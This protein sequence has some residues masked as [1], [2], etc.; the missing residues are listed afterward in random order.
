MDR[1]CRVLVLLLV[2]VPI[3]GPAVSY[4]DDLTDKQND[5]EK[6]ASRRQYWEQ[7]LKVAQAEVAT[8]RT[9]IAGNQARLAQTSA[10]LSAAKRKALAQQS[11]LKAEKQESV[12]AL[13]EAQAE[14]EAS[15]KDFNKQQVDLTKELQ[16]DQQDLL[17]AQTEMAQ[18]IARAQDL[19]ASSIILQ[20]KIDAMSQSIA[21]RNEEL[22]S[23]LVRVY[24]VSRTSTLELILASNSFN[25]AIARITLL[26]HIGEHDQRLLDQLA[27]DRATTQHSQ[28][29]LV[30]QQA[31]VD[32]LKKETDAESRVI[33]LRTQQSQD[34]L[35]QVGQQLVDAES[36]FSSQQ[37]DLN[38]QIKAIQ[39]QINLAVVRAAATTQPLQQ[40]SHQIQQIQVADNVNLQK[41]E[42]DAAKAAAAAAQAQRDIASIGSTIKRLQDEANRAAA[43]AAQQRGANSA[44]FAIPATGNG[45]L[46]R[47][48][49]GV[50]TQGF[51]PSVMWGEP[52][53]TWGG[54]YYVHFHTGID[55]AAAYGSPLLAAGNGVVLMTSWY[56]GYGNCVIIAH[57]QHLST[58]YGHLSG[59]AVRPG[60]RV[61]QGQVIGYEGSTG[62]STGPHVH[63]EVRVDGQFQNPWSYVG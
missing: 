7:Q 51:G 59:F 29:L 5:L 46:M 61:V 34:L 2:L 38:Q 11:G 26:G 56:G 19:D 14:L 1:L 36:T 9:R 35:A 18:A 50:I 39:S 52:A 45:G 41:S 60:Q 49:N 55:I 63:F 53:V 6:A 28:K 21:R 42:Q 17:A 12:N 30:A 22:Q 24:K 20:G 15:R 8:L 3:V 43:L 27:S 40:A 58:L 16:T 37:D 31:E 57:N 10:K 44:S 32:E 54:R 47:P 33:A 48:L 62:Y 23:V 25:D 13:R 4:A